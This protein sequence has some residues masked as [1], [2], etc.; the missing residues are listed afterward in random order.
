MTANYYYFA[1]QVHFIDLEMMVRKA[2]MNVISTVWVFT[3]V[4][5]EKRLSYSE[6]CLLKSFKLRGDQVAG[7]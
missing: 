1:S 6:R 4:R 5:K 3:L 7:M 2:R